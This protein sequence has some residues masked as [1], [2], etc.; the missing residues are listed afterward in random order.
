MEMFKQNPFFRSRLPVKATDEAFVPVLAE[1]SES[2]DRNLPMLIALA[3]AALAFLI[4]LV[5]STS[6][7]YHHLHHSVS[8]TSQTLPDQPPQD[9]VPQNL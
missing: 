7:L 2:S 1:D 8:N 9:L 6:W 3:V 5:V 4:L